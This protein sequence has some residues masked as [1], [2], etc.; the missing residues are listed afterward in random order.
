M[1]VKAV[2]LLLLVAIAS[3]LLALLSTQD[4]WS[5]EVERACTSPRYGLRLAASR[6]VAQGG[7]DAVPAIRAFATAKGINEVPASLVA[8]LA[9]DAPNDAAVIDL[10]REWAD[11][12]VFYWRSEAMRG[13]SLRAPKLP[14]AARGE[15]AK[16]FVA[17]YGDAGWLTRVHAQLGGVLLGD[18]AAQQRPETDPRARAK[19]AMLL[20]QHTQQQRLQTLLDALADERTFQGD[21]WGQRLAGDVHKVLKTWLGDAH[22]LANGGS[23]PD[24]ATGL[25]QLT[26]ACAKKSGQQLTVPTIRRDPATT[27]AGGFEILSCQFGDAFV[28]WTAAGEVYVGL[29]QPQ[30]VRLPADAWKALDAERAALEMPSTLGTVVCDNLRLR[31]EQPAVHVKAAPA[32]L[33]AAASAWL[34][35]L[36]QSIEQADELPNGQWLWLRKGLAQ[37]APR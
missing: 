16:L 36:A 29:D 3:P 32:S 31:W 30:V 17:H 10:L 11:T 15:L 7:A 28:Q 18:Q 5:K 1:K 37:F 14:E 9:D 26:A 4:A 35:H 23:F 2:H 8:A 27:F 12:P 22:P 33:P 20:L 21:P 6:K 13:L 34:A 19:T 24:T 25:Q